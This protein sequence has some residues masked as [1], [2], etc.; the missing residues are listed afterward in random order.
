MARKTLQIIR[1]KWQNLRNS[2]GFHNVAL[3][4]VFVVIASLFW[5]VMW[6]NDSIQ[7]T[8]DVRLR[9]Y[10]V[11]DSVTFIDNPPAG[12]HVTVRDKGTSL[13]R[14]GLLHEPELQI[15][16]LEYAEGGVFRYSASDLYSSL[17]STFGGSAQ[18]TS[19]SLD[20]LRL[21][22]TTNPG[23]E[24][25]IV[26]KTDVTTAPGYVI[27][28]R[29]RCSTNKVMV[30][31]NDP[32]I[33]TLTSVHTLCLLKRNLSASEKMSVKVVAIPGAKIV[34]SA[35][36]VYIPVEALVKK[37]STVPVKVVNAPPNESLLIF[38]ANVDVTYFVPLSKFNNDDADITVTAD[39]ND[40]QA[41]RGRRM[42]VRV[43]SHGSG[44]VNVTLLTDSVEYTIVRQ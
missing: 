22:Y 29:L 27:A 5:L 14:S 15:N 39:F 13:L 41:H 10:N 44:I 3:Y 28:G 4:L 18:I 23:R 24:V 30:F 31:S 35:V 36:Q 17:R 38:P 12:L 42:P 32:S 33:D 7:E 2:R 8:F 9:I 6:L 20:S 16:F 21:T 26:L 34:P 19:L 40:M 37:K 25:P 11:P 43:G 1:E